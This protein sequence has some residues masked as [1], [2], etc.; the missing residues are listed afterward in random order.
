MATQAVLNDAAVFRHII[1]FVDSGEY[2]FLAGVCS[3]WQAAYKAAK[4]RY[5]VIPYLFMDLQEQCLVLETFCSNV[6]TKYSAVMASTSR[7]KL[8][9]QH[10]LSFFSENWKLQ[11]LAGRFANIQSLEL[12]H[13]YGM[14]YSHH[15]MAG[16]AES[17]DVDKL[18]WLHIE[19]H[20][21]SVAQ[22]TYCAAKSGS[23]EMMEWLHVQ[24]CVFSYK[25]STQAAKAGHLH[26]LRFLHSIGCDIDS[27]ASEAAAKLG[28]LAILQWL[29]ECGITW[30][31]SEV[32]AAAAKS[33]NMQLIQWMTENHAQFDTRT[34][35]AAA[36][37]GHLDICKHLRSFGC[38]WNENVMSSIIN[39]ASQ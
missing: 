29:D 10:G 37:F 14:P 39:A 20:C 33:G 2:L 25:T 9:Q 11:Y 18:K 24:E 35:A 31:E 23:I 5:I 6:S 7:M 16:A 19:Q 36:E 28:S 17:G 8:A 12:A 30:R 3:G 13:S 34:M 21:G 1:K 26:I 32:F 15:V 38:D 4:A 22:I 27:S